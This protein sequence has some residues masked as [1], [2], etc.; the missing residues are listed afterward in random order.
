[1]RQS[2]IKKSWPWRSGRLWRQLEADG[3]KFQEIRQK[4]VLIFNTKKAGPEKS[5]PAFLLYF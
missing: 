3:L 1:M 2:N 5:S 4:L